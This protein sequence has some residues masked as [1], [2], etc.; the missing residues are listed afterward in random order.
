MSEEKKETKKL[1]REI[2][3]KQ[4]EETQR[5]IDYA[6]RTIATLQQQLQQQQG[7]LSFTQH[8]LT[9]FD[10]PS[11]PEEKKPLEVK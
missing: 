4:V 3:Q 10:I 6:Q 9:Q 11:I 5:G 8:L 1:S 7:I 2:L